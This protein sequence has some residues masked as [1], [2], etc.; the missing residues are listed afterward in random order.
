MIFLDRNIES[1][2]DACKV[3]DIICPIL[4]CKD[5]NTNQINLDP[6]SNANAFDTFGY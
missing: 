5:C 6:Y 1:I 4:S 2:M 3:A